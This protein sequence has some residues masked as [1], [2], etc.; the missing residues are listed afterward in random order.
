[1]RHSCARICRSKKRARQF[2]GRGFRPLSTYLYV[3]TVILIARWLWFYIWSYNSTARGCSLAVLSTSPKFGEPCPWPNER[4]P[5]PFI[6]P[7]HRRAQLGGDAL[8][9]KRR[10]KKSSQHDPTRELIRLGRRYLVGTT[11]FEPQITACRE[12][13]MSLLNEFQGSELAQRA[14]THQSWRLL[15]ILTVAASLALFVASYPVISSWALLVVLGW[16]FIAGAAESSE[17]DFRRS[18]PRER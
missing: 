6:R 18:G 4:K 8:I 9:S 12:R 10:S 14:V 11:M 16:W 5:G 7:S 15:L 3:L 17:D 13:F 1:M 2:C